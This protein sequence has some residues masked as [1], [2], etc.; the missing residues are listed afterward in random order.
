MMMV[1]TTQGC[2]V[3]I[4]SV[5]NMRNHFEAKFKV[6]LHNCFQVSQF[7]VVCNH[8]IPGYKYVADMIR[9]GGFT[10]YVVTLSSD[11]Q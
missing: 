11:A 4:P 6:E 2:Y 8:L 3:K 5:I 9:E 10:A 7:M 1:N